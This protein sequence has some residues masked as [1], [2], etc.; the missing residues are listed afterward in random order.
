MYVK[1]ITALLIIAMLLLAGCTTGTEGTTT[2]KTTT[3]AAEQTTSQAGTTASTTTSDEMGEVEITFWHAMTGGLEET[4]ISMTDQFMADHPNIKVTLQNQS[5]YGDLSQKLTAT[6]QSPKNLPTI[7]Q[8]YPDWVLEM[9]DAGMLVDLAQ[10]INSDD[11]TVAF[12]NWDDILPGLRDGVTFDGK[13]YALPFNKSTEV[14]WY[15][16]TLLDE[17][18]IAVPTSY[19]EL[20]EA[21]AKIYQAKGIPGAGFDS[22][23]NYFST[24]LI[25]Q[26]VVFDA[27]LDVTSDVAKE[28][29]NYYLQGIKDG[30]FRI[31]GT[32]KYLSGPLANEQL[33]MYIGSNAGEYYVKQGVADK[34]EYAAAPYP[35]KYAIQQGTD[36]YMFNSA[37]DEQ[38]LA[39]Y[40]Y[41]QHL[42]SKE[43]QIDWA[44]ATGYMPIRQSAISDA[45]YAQS[46]SAVAAILDSATKNLYTRPLAF[47]SQ[48]AYNDTN[49]FLEELLSDPSSNLEE[50]L[51]NFKAIYDS[52][53]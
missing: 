12:D 10:F 52:A 19:Q 43:Q 30:Y 16:K 24:Y 17:L 41:L 50:A 25:N 39:A 8:A 32:D 18:N 21:A 15:N 9:M 42:T 14:L 51:Q 2:T 23:S 36:I 5:S 22:L 20:A 48:Q 45:R 1:K 46:D 7:T 31:A 28:A 40:M 34:F 37:S 47:G 38:Q 44:L 6:M 33:A 29:A 3:T 4:L 49:A 35:A 11:A 53:W 26:D 13:I 27:Q